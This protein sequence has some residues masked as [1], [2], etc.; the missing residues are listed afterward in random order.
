MARET[1]LQCVLLPRSGCCAGLWVVSDFALDWPSI[2]DDD[3]LRGE[4][5]AVDRAEFVVLR[6]QVPVSQHGLALSADA[7]SENALGYAR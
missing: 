1:H 2:V 5:L 6:S 7:D 4:P 3:Y